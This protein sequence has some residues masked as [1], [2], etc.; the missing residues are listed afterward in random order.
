MNENR[1]A[2]FRSLPSDSNIPEH[3]HPIPSSFMRH[4]AN[5][6]PPNLQTINEI[7]ADENIMNSSDYI[8]RPVV[9]NKHKN[10]NNLATLDHSSPNK[11]EYQIR[12]PKEIG[13]EF[14]YIES[15]HCDSD[16]SN[17]SSEHSTIN[18]NDHENIQTR[19]ENYNLSPRIRLGNE[20]FAQNHN[21]SPNPRANRLDATENRN[22]HPNNPALNNPV[23]QNTN[24]LAAFSQRVSEEVRLLL[25]SHFEFY[26]FNIATYISLYLISKNNINSLP[27]I[28]LVWIYSLIQIWEVIRAPYRED[29]NLRIQKRRKAFSIIDWVSIVIYSVG[30]LLK[31]GLNKEDRVDE[32]ILTPFCGL[33]IL[34]LLL[35]IPFKT[36]PGNL[37]RKKRYALLKRTTFWVQFVLISLKLDGYIFATWPV[38]LLL[39]IIAIGLLIVYSVF[40]LF[41]FLSVLRLALRRSVMIRG[42]QAKIQ[43]LGFAWS[44]LVSLFSTFWMI[45]LV[46][47]TYRLNDH[48]DELLRKGLKAGLIHAIILVIITLVLNPWLKIFLR[49]LFFQDLYIRNRAREQRIEQNIKFEN[50]ESKVSYL[51]MI[52]PT[53]HQVFEEEIKSYTVRQLTDWKQLIK[54][55]KFTKYFTIK[56]TKDSTPNMSKSLEIMAPTSHILD[57]DSTNP[58]INY[59][60]DD[61]DIYQTIKRPINP[62][63]KEADPQCYICVQ[64]PPAAIIMNCGHSGICYECALESWRKGDKCIMCRQKIENIL[65]VKYYEKLNIS[66]VFHGTKKISELSSLLQ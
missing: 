59:S 47:I 8:K 37:T 44:F 3:I 9:P 12:D 30:F 64:R 25:T 42:I 46:G 1:E 28:I 19:I 5:R 58:Q 35:Y 49:Y 24:E 43:V 54:Q 16:T 36:P 57:I 6:K 48:K 53:F 2:S 66:K 22:H 32:V 11:N 56:S 18:E 21:N 4:N 33:G 63:L 34:N 29:M 17:A 7:Q 27:Q 14:R 20:L 39:S 40:P 52:S 31:A 23:Q 26:L 61:I 65:K 45:I 60:N 62:D 13:I 38:V 55:A 15:K 50:L 41:I 10:Q 51:F